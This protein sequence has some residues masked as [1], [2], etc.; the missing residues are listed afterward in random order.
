MSILNDKLQAKIDSGRKGLVVYLTA[1]YPDLAT[2][3]E[4][5]LAAA[6]AGADIIEIGIPFSDPIADGPV[7]QKAATLSLQGGTTT[8]KILDMTRKIRSKSDVPLAVMTYVN[9]I[10]NYGA[11]TFIRDFGQAGVSGIIVP[12]LPLEE[13]GMLLETCNSHGVDLIQFIAPTSTAGRIE[14]IC[15]PGGRLFILHLNHRRDR[16]QGSRLS[17]GSGGDCRSAKIHRHTSGHRFRHQYAGGC[18]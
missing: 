13:A 1:G 11:E 4:A 5:I 6:A 10:L 2:S 8:A 15:R 14:A 9:T 3:C 7:I 17:T 12:D 18:A 16:W